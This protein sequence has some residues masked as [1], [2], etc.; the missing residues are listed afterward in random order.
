MLRTHTCGELRISDAGNIVIH[1]DAKG[2]MHV[3][4][5]GNEDRPA[6]Q[7]DIEDFTKMLVDALENLKNPDDVVSIITHHA[8]EHRIVQSEAVELT[9]FLLDS[10]GWD[11]E[12]RR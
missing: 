2:T 8:V 4:K 12:E 5:I 1:G 9:Q 6:T 10:L 7:K 11:A 3:W